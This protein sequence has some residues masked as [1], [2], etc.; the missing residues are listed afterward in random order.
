MPTFIFA[1]SEPRY[2]YFPEA[3]AALVSALILTAP[4]RI[5][6]S[7]NRHARPFALKD[8]LKYP[9]R[10]GGLAIS[11]MIVIGFAASQGTS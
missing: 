6:T 3:F 9:V 4:Y 7:E 11:V 8:K 5:L 1:G 2:Y 10:V